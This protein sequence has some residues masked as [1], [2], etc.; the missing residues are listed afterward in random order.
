MDIISTMNHTIK[1]IFRKAVS[2]LNFTKWCHARYSSVNW[3]FDKAM[4]DHVIN[5]KITLAVK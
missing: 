5:N 1:W 2:Q 4:A 3:L